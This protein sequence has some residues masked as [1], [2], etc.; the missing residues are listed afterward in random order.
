VARREHRNLRRLSIGKRLRSTLR[1]RS[2]PLLGLDDDDFTASLLSCGLG[3]RRN[4]L[5]SRLNKLFT[6]EVVNDTKYVFPKNLVSLVPTGYPKCE[7]LDPA[8]APPEAAP[9]RAALTTPNRQRGGAPGLSLH[10]GH[11]VEFP[12][13]RT[14]PQE[15]DLELI[16]QKLISSLRGTAPL[17]TVEERQLI[18]EMPSTDPSPVPKTDIP[19]V[20]PR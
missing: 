7:F 11:E 13:R 19:A 4:G 15:M 20:D 17:L 3:R 18:Q 9:E 1:S 2:F 6:T 12:E 5:L 10:S 14:E 8:Q 16:L